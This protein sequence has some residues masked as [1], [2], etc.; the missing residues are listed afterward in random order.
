MLRIV[1]EGKEWFDSSPMNPQAHSTYF[2][3]CCTWTKRSICLGDHTQCVWSNN[4][5]IRLI[6]VQSIDNGKM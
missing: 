4:K 1:W 6:L 2:P 3:D 5:M